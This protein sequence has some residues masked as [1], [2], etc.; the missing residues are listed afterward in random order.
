M[1]KEMELEKLCLM[2]ERVKSDKENK[3]YL[4]HLFRRFLRVALLR[5]ERFPGNSFH[6]YTS[7][8]KDGILKRDAQ[9]EFYISSLTHTSTGIADK[10]L[11]TMLNELS[12]V[13]RKDTICL[14]KQPHISQ[15]RVQENLCKKFFGSSPQGLDEI[16][17]VIVMGNGNPI[18]L[19]FG[20]AG[21]IL[22]LIAIYQTKCHRI[23]D[24][25]S[26]I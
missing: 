7:L 26:I 2:W 6:G 19:S 3:E 8:V 16:L 22:G 1:I 23:H 9:L 24:I 12:I 4:T 25:L 11:C 14:F 18:R 13:D 10:E 17:S 20:I 5:N 21:L 15:H